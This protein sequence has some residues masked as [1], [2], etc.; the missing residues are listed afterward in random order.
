M[1]RTEDGTFLFDHCKVVKTGHILDHKLYVSVTEN[2]ENIGKATIK[3]SK[4]SRVPTVTHFVLYFTLQRQW[5]P[6]EPSGEV[7]FELAAVNFGKIRTWTTTQVYFCSKTKYKTCFP[8]ITRTSRT[9]Q[10]SNPS[11]G[12]HWTA[13]SNDLLSFLL[14]KKTHIREFKKK[15]LERELPHIGSGTF[16]IVYKGHVKTRRHSSNTSSSPSS[17]SYPSLVAIK[18]IKVSDP[19]VLAEWKREVELMWYAY[20]PYIW[21]IFFCISNT[22]GTVLPLW[23]LY[24]PYCYFFNI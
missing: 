9:E 4:L 19:N 10:C 17:S 18:D 23:M 14:F 7:L 22:N 5:Y 21:N 24:F 20:K 6:L 16:G 2:G 11:P 15:E 12:R 13:G 1:E 3:T 8:R